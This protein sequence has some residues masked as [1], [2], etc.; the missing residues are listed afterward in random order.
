MP[1]ETP[2]MP[3]ETYT[4]LLKHGA[5]KDLGLQAGEVAFYP[6]PRDISH[7]LVRYAKRL[8]IVLVATLAVVMFI[9]FKST[10]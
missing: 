5:S 3:S 2:Y 8:V 10:L 1:S 9:G 7:R 4:S 6:N